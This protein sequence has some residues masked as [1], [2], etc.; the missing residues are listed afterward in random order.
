MWRRFVGRRSQRSNA[1]VDTT[2]C[3]CPRWLLRH[4]MLPRMRMPIWSSRSFLVSSTTLFKRSWR[5]VAGLHWKTALQTL[6]VIPSRSQSVAC[7]VSCADFALCWIWVTTMPYLKYFEISPHAFIEQSLGSKNPLVL[8][9]AEVETISGFWS[10]WVTE[11]VGSPLM[12]RSTF[13]H[14]STPQP[15]QQICLSLLGGWWFGQVLRYSRWLG[16][17]KH[18][19]AS[20]FLVANDHH[21]PSWRVTLLWYGMVYR[22]RSIS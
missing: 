16:N 1:F 4:T 3:Q 18:F 2:A 19:Y 14:I 7:N 20:L 12:P 22:Y 11:L 9:A 6:M 17:P 10:M 15:R 8:Q 21:R 5:T 13:G